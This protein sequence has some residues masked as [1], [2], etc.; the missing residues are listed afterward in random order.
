[1]T[2]ADDDLNVLEQRLVVPQAFA[3]PGIRRSDSAV[4]DL[5]MSAK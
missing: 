5:P 1:M 4:S 3:G 2:T